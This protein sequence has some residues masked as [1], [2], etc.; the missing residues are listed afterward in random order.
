MNMDRNR[1]ESS[2]RTMEYLQLK[3]DTDV[4]K[5]LSFA[6]VR[7]RQHKYH[8]RTAA[9]EK[10]RIWLTC[11]KQECRTP[12]FFFLIYICIVSWLFRFTQS[13]Q[14]FLF[15]SFVVFLFIKI[16]KTFRYQNV[17]LKQKEMNLSKVVV[18]RDGAFKCVPVSSLVKGDVIRL[19]RKE[20][21]PQSV[22][23]L[24]HP[25]TEYEQGT[26]FTENTGRAIVT[27]S[28]KEMG[29]LERKTFPE[30]AALQELFLR[31]G[32]SFRPEFFEKNRHNMDGSITVVGFEEMYFPSKFQQEKFY[33]F[34]EELK[35][36]GVEWFFFTRQ[37]KENAF[38]I[39]KQAGIVEQSREI[40]D[41]KQFLLLKNVALERQIGSIRIYCGLS[42]KEKSQVITMW[43]KYQKQQEKIILQKPGK[44]LLM[45]NFNELSGK[46]KYSETVAG[47][48][49]EKGEGALQENCVYACCSGGNEKNDLCFKNCWRD[50]MVKYLVGEEIQ[51]KFFAIM[52]KGERQILGSLC[53]FMFLSIL[54]SL[55]LP[56]KGNM[57]Q[58]MQT[59][60]L[61]CT[62]YIIGKEIVQ[63]GFRYWF[64]KK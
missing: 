45:S 27:K 55:Y 2:K 33:L 35:K 39:G 64:L 21:V 49:D 30:N 61:F 28:Q 10:K 26:L 29:C 37:D 31:Q 63:E 15:V 9:K 7:H 40:I 52:E 12:L 50:T 36:T 23:S 59:G 53:I 51:Q 32:I 14:L 16:K 6:Q 24:Q 62:I 13:V 19:K 4:Q 3:Y 47:K 34:M 43:K 41:K 46:E 18:L 42:D 1:E 56:E 38:L 44:L 8:N 5:G 22:I 57:R 48:E 20:K 17:F 11:F 54:L 25:Y 58:I 60:G